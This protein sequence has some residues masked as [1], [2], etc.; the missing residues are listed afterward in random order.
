M[1]LIAE[2][3]WRRRFG[4]DPA[5]VGRALRLETK[6]FTVIGVVPSRQAFPEWADVWL[7]FPW[8]EPELVNTRKYHPLRVIARLKP[9]VREEQAQAEMHALA[10]RLA[11][12][13]ARPIGTVGADCRNRQSIA[14]VLDH[15]HGTL[16]WVN[17]DD[18][19]G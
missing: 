9:R 14:K 8:I 2:K 11:A 7:P 19:A 1:A 5:I 10:A 18:D 12:E 15:L 16:L 13:P 6:S 4:A 17:Y 3:L